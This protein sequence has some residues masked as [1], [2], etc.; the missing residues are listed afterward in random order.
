M[1]CKYQFLNDLT[2][3]FESHKSD[4]LKP[5]SV[6]STKT[7][8]ADPIVCTFV[9]YSGVPF[10]ECLHSRRCH[11]L[12][13]S[14]LHINVTLLA[15]STHLTQIVMRA[16]TLWTLQPI[17]WMRAMTQSGWVPIINATFISTYTFIRREARS[18]CQNVCYI[19]IYAGGARWRRLVE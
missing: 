11:F 1:G 18:I 7:A 14:F 19:P 3:M 8:S 15:Y 5:E 17:R 12:P 13:D 2:H 10:E 6:P 9:Y 4:I 16:G